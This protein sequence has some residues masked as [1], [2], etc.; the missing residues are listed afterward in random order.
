MKKLSS[1]SNV[2]NKKSVQLTKAILA[3]VL[4]R[5]KQ[6]DPNI[7]Q[8]SITTKM[9]NRLFRTNGR[10]NV[11]RYFVKRLDEVNQER[12]L[13]IPWG[14][15]FAFHEFVRPVLEDMITFDPRKRWPRETKIGSKFTLYSGIVEAFLKDHLEDSWHEFNGSNNSVARTETLCENITRAVEPTTTFVSENTMTQPTTPFSVM[16]NLST[17]KNNIVLSDAEPIVARAPIQ[18]QPVNREQPII[19]HETT[20]EKQILSITELQS[21]IKLIHIAKQSLGPNDVYNMTDILMSKMK[22]MHKLHM[23]QIDE[24]M[25]LLSQGPRQELQPAQITRLN[26]KKRKLD[27]ALSSL[28]KRNKTN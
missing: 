25:N 28:N 20:A 12:S 8:H 11:Y 26:N 10:D 4:N 1:V 7:F 19:N 3:Q 21:T 16:M 6:T 18:E 23:Q 5:N 9:S 2:T 14:K 24:C 17:A 13:N 22:K 15:Y 27:T